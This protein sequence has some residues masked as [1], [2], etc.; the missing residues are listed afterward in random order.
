MAID[1]DTYD[2]N[3][4][5]TCRLREGYVVHRTDESY[6]DTITLKIIGAKY[7]PFEVDEFVVY[8]PEY[9]LARLKTGAKVNSF[10]CK[11]FAIESRFT[12]DFMTFIR[13][14]HI[15]NIAHK[16]DGKF[17]RNCDEFFAMAGPNRDDGAFICH[18]CFQNPWR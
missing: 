14:R 18:S 2:I 17:C 6:D 5:V 15:V 12:G 11:E 3:D 7:Q 1:F 10:L 9:E 13:A 4:I 16:A 8:V